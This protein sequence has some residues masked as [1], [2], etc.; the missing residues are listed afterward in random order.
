MDDDSGDEVDVN[1]LQN[2]IKGQRR[3]SL[4]A[5]GT[6]KIKNELVLLNKT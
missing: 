2:S 6:Y 5:D 3:M 1:Q 4:R